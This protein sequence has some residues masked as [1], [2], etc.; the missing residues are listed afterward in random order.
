MTLFS[1]KPAGSPIAIVG[2]EKANIREGGAKGSGSAGQNP[3]LAI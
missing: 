1:G 3:T 2:P